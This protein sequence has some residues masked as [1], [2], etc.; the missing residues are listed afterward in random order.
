MI[1]QLSGIAALTASLVTIVAIVIGGLWALS[2][3]TRERE[4]I[5]RLQLEVNVRIISQT[6]QMLVL[7]LIA[8]VENKGRVRHK[9]TRLTYNL[10]YACFGD[11]DEAE[12]RDGFVH[13][14]PGAWQRVIESWLP[15]NW[16]GFVEPGVRS[17]YSHMIG[18]AANASLIHLSGQ[19]SYGRA[20]REI[21][22]STCV[23]GV[24]HA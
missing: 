7:E 3:F 15:E 14:I 19:F 24:D 12:L 8:F 18:I 10:A 6:S 9:F 23:I 2:R 16:Y 4:A 1:Q 11:G 13:P 21:E 5:P 20:D 17:K 22:E